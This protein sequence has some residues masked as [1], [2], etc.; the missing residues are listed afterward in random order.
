MSPVPSAFATHSA[1]AEPH[2]NAISLPFGDH[3]GL[4]P[5]DAIWRRLPSA[6]L[7][8][9]MRPFPDSKAIWRPSGDQV[10]SV[11]EAA[12]VDH[13]G[14]DLAKDGGRSRRNPRPSSLTT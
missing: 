3:A 11:S 9:T 6:I 14:S 13:F 8:A 2:W 12:M 10:G 7:T 4:K 5:S 1:P